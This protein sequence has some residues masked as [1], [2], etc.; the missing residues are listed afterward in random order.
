MG[1][2]FNFS[3]GP[4]VLPE[5]VLKEA[6]S[7]MLD[8]RGSGMSVMEMSHRSKVYGSIIKDAEER[9]IRLL[10]VPDTHKVLF[11]QGGATLQFSMAAMNLFVNGKTCDYIVA[12]NWGN[13]AY[14]EAVAMG[15]NVNK[16]A[17][18]EE[19]KFTYIPKMKDWDLSDAEYIHTT[20][21]NTIFGTR[22]DDFPEIDDKIHICDMS[23]DFMSRPVDVSK[24]GLI[25]AGAQKNAGPAGV[26]IVIIRKD[27]IGLE[28]TE[29][30]PLYLKYKT[31]SDKDSMHN[32]PPC[33]AIYMCGLVF[34]WIEEEIGG[35]EKM[36]QHNEKK[37]GLIYDR[38]DNSDG[39][40]RSPVVYKEQRSL[41]NIPFVLPTPELDAE[42]IR[43]A[44]EKGMVNLK[45]YRT[46]GGIRASVYNS[47]PIEGVERLVQ[48]MDEFRKANQ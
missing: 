36:R 42:F 28:G 47:H 39:F 43:Q 18:S 8:Y 11:I 29:R 16:A 23:S 30:L 2:V 13:K 4:A 32:T 1:R 7:E 40:Y 26:T 41:M 37:A 10:N 38:I 45:G 34:K 46:V 21:N 33:Y 20:S 22:F 6:Q 3:A 12:G 35:L 48:F 5:S 25:Y 19:D 27:L 24:F 31:H 9:V 14:K 15:M 44:E 17:S